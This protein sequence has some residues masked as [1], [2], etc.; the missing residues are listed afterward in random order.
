MKIEFKIYVFDLFMINFQLNQ[1][2]WYKITC[3]IDL[4]KL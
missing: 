3:I 4:H 2:I 1:I